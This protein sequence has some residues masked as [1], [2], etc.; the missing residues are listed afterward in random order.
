MYD[1]KILQVKEA[2]GDQVTQ[3]QEVANLMT[4][5]SKADRELFWVLHLN[6]KKK[7]I[8]KELVSM[9]TLTSSLV[10]PREV[11]RK[12]IINST[13]AIITVHNHP[14]SG[15]EPSKEDWAVWDQL[16]KAGKI[17]GV[18]IIDHLIIAHSD[19]S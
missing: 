12:A 13:Q 6:N 11:F 18:D 10:H 16:D 2:T 9:G 3:P 4:E 17:I 7:I 5:E 1:L 14:S 8:E 19:N 15:I